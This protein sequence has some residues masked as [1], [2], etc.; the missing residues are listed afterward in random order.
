MQSGHTEFPSTDFAITS[1]NV[2]DR[3]DHREIDDRKQQELYA[4]RGLGTSSVRWLRRLG[5]YVVLVL[6]IAAAGRWAF[7]QRQALSPVRIAQELS[8]SLQV[9]VTVQDSRLRAAPA[10]AVILSGIDLGGRIRLDEVALEFTAPNLWQAMVAGQRRWGDIVISPMTLSFDQAAV[11]LGW[12]SSLD[13]AVPN[14]VTKVRI[15][16]LR[17]AG[18]KLLPDRYEVVTRRGPDAHFGSITLHRLGDS[19]TMQ[20]QVT[21]APNGGP[22]ALQLDASDFQPPF[23]PRAPWSEL[24]ASGHVSAGSLEFDQFTMGSAFGSIDGHLSVHQLAPS[25]WSAQG[26][27]STVGLD[28]PTLLQQLTHSPQPD[29]GSG[30]EV[31]A[32]MLGTASIEASF[33][34]AGLSLEDALNRLVAEGQINIRNAALNGINLGYVASRPAESTTPSSG[35]S[36]RFTRLEASF[37]TSPNGVSFR[38]IRGTAGALSTRGELTVGHDLALNGL[39]HVDLGGT[40]VQA[41]LR[42]HVRGSVSNPQFVR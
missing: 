28:I 23:A 21:P 13:R 35:S 40:R 3:L 30:Q 17:L 8:T 10:P 5:P 36:T 15:S 9:Q 18:S 24:V 33:S 14:N 29:V 7:D 19:G 26:K 27:A 6:I 42:I 20:L 31:S 22:M 4:R 11:M 34:G 32:P 1:I 25:A 16:E 12:L 2:G 38:A 37:V 41:P 39:L